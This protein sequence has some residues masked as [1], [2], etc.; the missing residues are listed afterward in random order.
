VTKSPFDVLELITGRVGKLTAFVAA[1]G[2]LAVGILNYSEQV[3]DKLTALHLYTPAPCVEVDTVILPATVKLSEWDNMRIRVKGRSNCSSP[4]GLYV[5]FVRRS[6]RQP[7]FV[8]RVPHEDLPEC[9]GLAPFQVPRCWD[10]KKPIKLGKGTWEWEVLPP[11]LAQ[12]S[13]P[14]AVEKISVTWSVHDY[15][16]PTKPPLRVDNATIEIHNDTRDSS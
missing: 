13:N 4:F 11:P 5:T 6:S 10:P 8:L 1:L 3:R 16:A 12:L 9:K 14:R 15:D 7:E 2:G